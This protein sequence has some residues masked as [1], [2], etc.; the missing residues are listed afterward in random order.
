MSPSTSRREE[1]SAI[2]AFAEKTHPRGREAAADPKWRANWDSLATTADRIDDGA[3]VVGLHRAMAWFRDG[4]STLLPFEYLGG[5]PPAMSK[6]AFGLS[7]PLKAR[8]FHDGLWVTEAAGEAAALLGGRISRINGVSD[9]ELM[10]RHGAIWSGSDAWA[11]NWGAATLSPGM[12]QG[13]AISSDPHAP[14]RI[15]ASKPSGERVTASLT[16]RPGVKESLIKLDRPPSQHEVWAGAAKSISYARLLPEQG[17]LYVSIDEMGDV[18]GKTIADLTRDIFKAMENPDLQRIV[19]DLRRNGGGDNFWGEPIRKGIERS[20]FN[21]PGGLY[22]MTSPA[23]F[24]AAQ[25]L[26][27]RLERETYALFVGEPTGSS[28]NHFGDGAMFKGPVT[29]VTILCST[30]PWFDSYPMDKRDW[31]APDLPAPAAFAD[32]AAGRDA[33]LELALS[34]RTDASP[35]ELERD[36]VFYFRRESQKTAW[37]PFW[38][39]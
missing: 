33:A 17:A 29:G 11:H 8:T 30:L 28:P 1:S 23:T 25:N 37:R 32:W 7:L 10:R 26:A 31:I 15:E 13:H 38:R 3:Y 35:D 12:L 22:V 19:I 14:V 6:G 9:L 27:N 2:R 16:P 5:P 39:T 36:R 4:H 24:S 18:D 21:R 34:H 20:R